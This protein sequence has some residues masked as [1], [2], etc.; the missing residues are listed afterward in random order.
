MV[1]PSS[2]SVYRRDIAATKSTKLVNTLRSALRVRPVGACGRNNLLRAFRQKLRGS[3]Q[4]GQAGSGRPE[5]VVNSFRVGIEYGW[6]DVV[7]DPTSGTDVYFTKIYC[8]RNTADIYK[9][10]DP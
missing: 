7:P 5:T 8:N 10:I 1:G 3:R 2:E 6:T 9:M 4:A